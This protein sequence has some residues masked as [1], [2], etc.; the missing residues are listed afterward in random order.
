[1]FKKYGIHWSELLELEYW[2]PATFVVI[3]GMH[4]LFLRIVRYHF[5]TSWAP[6]GKVAMKMK[7]LSFQFKIVLFPRH[8][9]AKPEHCLNRVMCHRAR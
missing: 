9:S 7:T 1:M 4:T 3:D 6:T 8:S 5:A 2:D